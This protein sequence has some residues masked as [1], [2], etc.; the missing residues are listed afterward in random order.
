MTIVAFPYRASADGVSAA[1]VCLEGNPSSLVRGVSS[2]IEIVRAPHTAVCVDITVMHPRLEKGALVPVTTTIAVPGGLYQDPETHLVSFVRD[3]LARESDFI[4]WENHLGLLGP[5]TM[6]RSRQR[7]FVIGGDVADW[8][9]GHYIVTI[10]NDGIVTKKPI[11]AEF[12]IVE[13]R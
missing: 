9:R 11:Q 7:V 3:P 5:G 6:T 10:S 8:P 1:D 2:A 13:P 12:T 4:T